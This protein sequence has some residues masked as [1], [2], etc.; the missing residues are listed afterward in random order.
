MVQ[1]RSVL[2]LI[3]TRD[4][5]TIVPVFKIS[6]IKNVLRHN[7]G[8]KAYYA[9]RQLFNSSLISRNSKLQIYR[10]LVRPVVTYGSES[11]TLSMEKERALAVFERKILRK[12]Y[13]PVKENEL[14]RI[15]RN[16]EL[17]AIIKGENIVRF[18]KC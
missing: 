16:D 8:N 17:E 5:L 4:F 12:I 14:W 7:V 1:H 18:I 2:I 9:N 13:K 6:K 15:R 11:W 3:I 10:T